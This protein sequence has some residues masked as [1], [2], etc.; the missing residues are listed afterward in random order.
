[1]RRWALAL[2]IGACSSHGS[3]ADDDGSGSGSN[4][5]GGGGLTFA[6]VGDTRPASIDDTASYPTAIITEIY[7]AIAATPAQF[8]IS[9][10][11]YQYA[12][13]TG[14]DQAPQLALCMQARANYS[15]PVYPAMGNHECTGYTNSNCGSGNPDGITRNYTEF[16]N[17]MLA[18]IN[19]TLP[20]Y[21]EA[22]SASDNSWTAK[23][24]VIACNYW[25]DAQA[26]WL[27][28]QLAMPTTY[29]FVVRH[30]SVADMSSTMC[31]AS[32]A[33]INANPLTL[34]IVG[35]TH[36]YAHE[37]HEKE[38]INGIGGAPLTSGTNYGYTIVT[39]TATGTLTVTTFDYS[40]H[41]V[42]DSFTI[43]ATG[44][45]A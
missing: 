6:I 19:Q 38:I 23:V 17:A 16:A 28:Q 40:T 29:T 8:A 36:E 4:I 14:S 13:T 11:D 3:T 24:V 2:L 37:A 12:S 18:P 45:A 21:S 32:Q 22:I 1:M 44:S 7:Q 15:G 39:R 34:L 25:T 20:Y 10:G 33:T 5:D 26:T 42:I 35:H 9:T 41:A 43:A 27:Q 31:A 30:E